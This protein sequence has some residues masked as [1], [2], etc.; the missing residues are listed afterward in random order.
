[1]TEMQFYDGKCKCGKKLDMRITDV[2]DDKK[3]I[4]AWLIYGFCK[5]CR[6]TFIQGLFTQQEQ[7]E[8]GMDFIINYNKT[9][10]SVKQK[11]K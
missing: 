3:Q 4:I 9:I 11:R 5:K 1:M 7:P 8:L 10:S 2:K 6:T